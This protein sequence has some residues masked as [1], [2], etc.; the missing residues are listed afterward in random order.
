[1]DIAKVNTLDGMSLPELAAA[2]TQGMIDYVNSDGDLVR[3]SLIKT[4]MVT[5]E[6][7]LADLPD[8]YAPGSI[9]FLADETGKWRLGADG[10]WASLIPDAAE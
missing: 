10:T 8:D 5:A 4:V 9:A 7:D 2:I 6:S 1:M 3:N